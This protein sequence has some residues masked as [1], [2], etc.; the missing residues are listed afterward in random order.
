MAS[1]GPG[2]P[3]ELGV[4]Y[5]SVV[6][7]TDGLARDV[8]KGMRNAQRYA[9]ANPIKIKADI[10]VSHIGAIQVPVIAKVDKAKLRQELRGIDNLHAN[11]DLRTTNA[12]L[13]RFAAALKTKLREKRFI[14]HLTPMVDEQVL[15]Q[16]LSRLPEGTIKLALDV[17]T[18]EVHRFAADLRRRLRDANVVVPVGLSLTG[19]AAFRAELDALT[20]RRSIDVDVN[21]RGGLGALGGGSGGGFDSSLIKT[22][23]VASAVAAGIT[24]IGGAAGSALGAVGALGAGIVALGPAAAAATA[25]AVVGVQGIGDAFKALSSAADSAGADGEAQAKAIAA[26]HEQV[27]T[28]LE[29]VEDAQR[30]LADAQKDA[31]EAQSDLADAY[32]DAADELEDYQFKLKDAA[33]TEKEAALAVREA[34]DDVAKAKTPAEREKAILRLQRAE[35]RYQQAVEDNRDTQEEAAEAQAKGIEGSDQVTAAKDRIA[36]ADRRV[37]DAQEAL[38]KANAQVAKAQQAVTDA[39]NQGSAAQDKAAKALAELSPNARAFVLQARELGGLWDDLVGDPTQDALFAGSAEGI[40]ELAESALPVLGRG[41]T[42]VA[43]SMNQLTHSFADFWQ[44]PANL[45]AIESIFEGTARFIDGMGPGLQQMTTGFLSLG[46][47][48]APVAQ[49]I[50]QQFGGLLGQLGQAFTDAFA[51]GA[52]TQL[53]GNFGGLLEGLGEGLNSL[54]D[55]LIQIGNILGP[56]LGPLFAQFGQSLGGIMPALGQLGATFATTFTQLLPHLHTFISSLATGL[57]PVL[58]VVGDLLES[59]L[60]ALH[61][62]I[63]PLSEIAQVVGTA[64]AQAIDA[65]APAIGPLGT[66]FASLVT[67]LSPIL[68]VLAQV[69]SGLVQA[70]APALTTIFNALGPVIQ[71]W[72]DLMMPVFEE[73]QPILA[74]VAQQIGTALAGALEQIAPVLPSMA[75]AF[76]GLVEAIAPILPQLVEMA[77]ELLPPI[78]D[79]FVELSPVIVK[80]T[81]ALTWLIKEVIIPLVL[82]YLKKMTEDIASQF[83]NAANIVS[84]VKD[85][86][87]GAISA[88]G[89]FFSGLGSTVSDVW[90]SILKTIVGVIGNVGDFLKDLPSIK[91]PDIPGIPGR[92]TEV[93]FKGIGE[94]MRKWADENM[95]S[96]GLLRGPGSG[97]SD[98]MLIAASNG[99]FVVNAKSTAANLPLLEALNAGWVPSADFVRQLVHANAPRFAGGGLVTADEKAR[100][101]GGT[102]NLSLW[103]AIKAKVPDAVLTSA[104]TDHSIDGGFHP[105]GKA[106]DVAPNRAVLD[107]L[108]ANRNQL[109]QIIFDDPNKVWYNVGGERA[110]GAKARAIYGETT[111]A[112]HGDHI[113][114]AAM[115][116][117]KDSGLVAEQP[118]QVDNRSD[119]DK[120][121]DEIVRVGKE[122][123]MSDE[124]IVAALATGLVESELRNLDYGDRDSVGVFQQRNFD[125]WTHGGTRDRMNVGDSA[126]TFFEHYQETDPSLSPGDRAQAVQRSA[127]PD[128]Y[129]QRMDEAQRLYQE[130][131][132]RTSSTGGGSTSGGGGGSSTTDASPVFVTNWPSNLSPSSTSASPSVTSS[133]SYGSTSSTPS[134][135]PSSTTTDLLANSRAGG[136]TATPE[137]STLSSTPSTTDTT[138]STTQADHPLSGIEVPG[139][140]NDIFPVNELFDGPAP[141]YMADSPEQAFNNLQTQAGNLWERTTSD[142][143]GFFENNWQ[144]MLETG[145]GALGMGAS[146]G[147]GESMTV[148]NYGMDPL[149]AASAVERVWRR[150][151]L[152]NQRGGGFGR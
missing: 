104:K 124:A 3:V 33:L 99:E 43:T 136:A 138:T 109:A 134:S 5:L 121:V 77:A 25:T 94:S 92:G 27:A 83:Q 139:F 54:L 49:Q 14:V 17:S 98:S 79:L 119:K 131:Q 51:S 28:A 150:R 57:E 18:A 132:S 70:L 68:P 52:L 133:S 135:T 78:I 97:T 75:T 46:Q 37:A 110:E 15:R 80:L 101:G 91:I 102:V 87:G 62:L 96:G 35:L 71:Q 140:L 86:L 107:Y 38:V 16:R 23:A 63:G 149:S 21:R 60:S 65:L 120:V 147:G 8:R 19:L 58:P 26:A 85:I 146:G 141:W 10:D 105:K 82:P 41:M 116:E 126:R 95:A 56:T 118:N 74:D 31:E 6:G 44:A 59:L 114:V 53:I 122:M 61:P 117:F 40:R 72:A 45:G 108:W 42:E 129:G 11:V 32:K 111:M 90:K 22:T 1:P 137:S 24:A 123:G 112:Q 81:E 151:S 88:I 2:Q 144:E 93:G 89:E 39:I 47:A 34:R 115:N 69:V 103:Q 100:M 128:K 50:G 20:R 29:N 152:A 30:D 143:T 9:D 113:H 12:E 106:I 7:E 84:K 36:Q 148:N 66:A 13:N 4:S 127:Y 67:A 142:V 145:L 55:G 48:F 73:L 64:L 130:S 76:G 125:E